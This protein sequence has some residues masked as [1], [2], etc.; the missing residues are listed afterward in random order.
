VWGVVRRGTR[1][2]VRAKHMLQ[3]RSVRL[4]PQHQA[5]MT[6]GARATSAL[7]GQ[8]AQWYHSIHT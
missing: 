6:L 1:C 7:L 5:P 2:I 4:Q 8:T 3:A